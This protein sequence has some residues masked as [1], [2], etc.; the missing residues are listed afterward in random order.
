[1]KEST[2]PT[3]M[4]F[5]WF[6]NEAEEAAQFY[7]SV[8]DDSAIGGI[9]RYSESI[10]EA[11]GRQ[12]GSAMTV[13]FRLAGQSFTAINGG[14]QFKFTPA[15]SFFV[16]AADAGEA[17]RIF[18]PLAEGG[19]VLMPFQEYPFSELYGW[20]QD[21]YGVSWQVNAAPREQKIAPCLMFTGDQCGKAEEAMRFYTSLFP[22]SAIEAVA[23]YGADQAPNREGTVLHAVFSLANREF[24]AMDS[25]LEHAFSFTPAISFSVSC[26]S[27]EEIDRFWEHL[28]E[29]GD[30]SAQQCGWLKDRFGVS[31]QVVPD[32]LPTMLGDPDPAKAQRVTQ[33]FMPMKK[34]DIAALQRAYEGE[35]S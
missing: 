11:A 8:F 27:Q 20:V 13:S 31:W 17:E 1:M 15:V 29:G 12:A 7:V 19:T 30:P 5:L 9:M 18:T 24:R 32:V 2:N 26:D 34:F 22:D 10:A 23:R 16:N 33:A 25:G 3:P 28:T 6:D 21:R 14:P 4:P 35:P